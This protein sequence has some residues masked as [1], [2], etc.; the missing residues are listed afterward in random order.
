M[1]PGC[2]PN[3]QTNKQIK[4]KLKET[5]DNNLTGTYLNGKELSKSKSNVRYKDIKIEN[6]CNQGNILPR[7]SRCKLIVPLNHVPSAAWSFWGRPARLPCPEQGRKRLLSE[8]GWVRRVTITN[9]LDQLGH[10]FT[11]QGVSKADQVLQFSQGMEKTTSA[12]EAEA[13]RLAALC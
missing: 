1:C 8:P 11:P 9:C 5:T 10:N 6:L 13:R 4:T 12:P 2:W 3:K 7:S